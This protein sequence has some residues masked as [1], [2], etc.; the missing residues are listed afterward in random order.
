MYDNIPESA[1]RCKEYPV[2]PPG[3]AG[4]YDMLGTQHWEE[5]AEYLF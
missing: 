4:M 2:N 1:D 5:R 3:T